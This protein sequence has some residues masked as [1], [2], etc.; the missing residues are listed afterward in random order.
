MSAPR[1]LVGRFG[2][3]GLAVVAGCS[4]RPEAAGHRLTSVT[5][6]A[7]PGAVEPGQLDG[8]AGPPPYQLAPPPAG[9]PGR[10][11]TWSAPAGRTRLRLQAWFSGVPAGRAGGR[12]VVAYPSVQASSDGRRIVA[13]A[14]VAVFE[15]GG[16]VAAG[17]PNYAG[18]HRRAVEY[19]DL[20][21]PAVHVVRRPDGHVVLVGRFPTYTYRGG[22]DRNPRIRP[23]WTG[24]TYLIRVDAWPADPTDPTDPTDPASSASPTGP[25]DPPG[26]AGSAGAAIATGT[27]TLGS[28]PDA[29]T[30]T[31]DAG[32]PNRILLPNPPA[33][34]PTGKPMV[35]R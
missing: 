28:G 2:L 9:P 12:L 7:L 6:S 8:P 22:V 4:A 26:S 20:A 15:C 21:A 18:C 13:H 27:V 14:K 25:A 1:R 17:G 5:A 10:L 30:S 19:G 24:R 33:T 34:R 16:P 32:Y 35:P 23:R 3:V 29:A 31:V 11:A